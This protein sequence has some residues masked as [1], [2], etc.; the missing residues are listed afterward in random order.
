[1][2]LNFQRIYATEKLPLNLRKQVVMKPCARMNWLHSTSVVYFSSYSKFIRNKK[3]FIL[4]RRHLCVYL[5]MHVYVCTVLWLV[6]LIFS[7]AQDIWN[8]MVWEDAVCVSM[9]LEG[10]RQTLQSTTFVHKVPRQIQYLIWGKLW[11]IP[12]KLFWRCVLQTQSRYFVGLKTLSLYCWNDGLK[13]WKNSRKHDD[14]CYSCI[15]V[16]YLKIQ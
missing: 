2:S 13:C 7:R 6:I 4:L 5:C 12:G 16:Q 3:V 1:M 8:R 11:E 9:D 10:Y 14:S 15:K